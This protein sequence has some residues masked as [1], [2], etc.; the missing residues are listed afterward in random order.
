MSQLKNTGQWLI[1]TCWAGLVLWQIFWHGLIPPPGGNENWI[2]AVLATIPLLVLSP[3][4]MKTRHSTLVWGMFL[5]MLYFIVAVMETWSNE[6]QRITALIQLVLTCGFFIGLV[7]FNR[8]AQ[9]G[10]E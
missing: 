8:P 1:R 5:A 9:P 3:G 10:P 7:L 6:A 2:L 4:I